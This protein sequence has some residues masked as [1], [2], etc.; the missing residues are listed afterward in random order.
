MSLHRPPISIRTPVR[1]PNRHG[2]C[3]A[4]VLLGCAACGNPMTE[5]A[6]TP[7]SVLLLENVTVIDGTGAPARAGL[8]VAVTGERISAVGPADHVR[9]ISGPGAE[10]ID[11]SGQ[12]LIPGLW[13]MHVHLGGLDAGTR[14]GPAFIAHGVTGVRDMGSPVDEILTLRDRWRTASPRG[15]RLVAAGPILQGPL[16]FELPLVRSVDGPAEAR[17]A[18]DDLHRA[19]VDFIKVGDTVPPDAYRALVDRARG[20]GLPVAGHLPVGIGAADAALAGQRSIEHFGS[21]RFHGL[22]LASSSEEGP[23][24]RRVQVLLDAAREGDAA[25]DV[26]LFRADLTGPLAD[27]FSPQKAEALSRTFAERGTAQVPTLVAVRSV[28][29]TQA[30]GMTEQDRRT[31]PTPPSRRRFQR[32]PRPWIGQRP[33]RDQARPRSAADRYRAGRTPSRPEPATPP[34]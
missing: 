23:L 17:T 33:R 8:S 32:S 26:R 3:A 24:T 22:L 34:P 4:L 10:T 16:P 19:G 28:W 15:P 29:D 5:S 31:A 30:D 18:V 11:A 27:S 25:A 9:A 7:E 14:A 1:V 2:V 12:F 13:D 6:A 21:A 20:H